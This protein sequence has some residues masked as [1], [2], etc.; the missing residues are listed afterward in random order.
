MKSIRIHLLLI[1]CTAFAAAQPELPG[2]YNEDGSPHPI[3]KPKKLNGKLVNIL[4]YGADPADNGYDDRPA[5]EDAIRNASAATGDTVFLPN[6]VYNLNSR[7]YS[8]STAHIILKTGIHFMGESRDSVFLVSNFDTTTNMNNSTVILKAVNIYNLSI[9]RMHITSTY[10]G[11]MPVDG[12]VNNPD[13]TAPAYGIYLDDSGTSPSYQIYID[14][15]IVEKVWRMMIRVANTHDVTITNSEFMNATDVGG[16]GAGY[17]VCIQGEGHDIDHYGDPNDS[18]YNYVANCRFLGPHLRHGVLIQYHS[19][20]NL[21]KGNYLYHT[22]YDALDMH[23]EDE[24]LNDLDS[25]TVENVPGGGGVGLGNTGASHD[26][27]GP[28]NYIHGNTFIS[29]REGVKVYLGSPRTRIEQNIIRDGTLAGSKGILILNGPSTV[30]RGNSIVNNTGSGFIGINLA[31]DSGT[32]GNYY[33]VP[34]SVLIVGNSI[35]GNDYGMKLDR[36]SHIFLG[37]NSIDQNRIADVL[38]D[39]SVSIVEY[40]S[41][42]APEL[43]GDFRILSVGPNPFNPSV[44]IKFNLPERGEIA[45]SVYDISGQRVYSEAPHLMDAGVTALRWTPR[46]LSSGIYFL[47]LRWKSSNLIRKVNYIK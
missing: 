23:G 24:Y 45:V 21:V 26:A 32:L 31:Y 44:S 1:L 38:I 13:H 15:V 7:S 12:T 2:F 33:G 34:D 28:D 30:I 9:E 11:M 20:N 41:V 25:N 27:S 40:T 19:H 35:S 43:A 6:G 8:S 16:G 29:C 39:G 17:G 14:S 46:N 5:I 18:R 10:A 37:D 4:D 22:V 47:Q 42:K 36:G 3:Y